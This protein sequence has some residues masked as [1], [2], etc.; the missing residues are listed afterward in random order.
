[1]RGLPRLAALA[2]AAAAL[3]VGAAAAPALTVYG[4]LTPLAGTGGCLR[5]PAAAPA[6]GPGAS[7]EGESSALVAPGAVLVSSDSQTVYVA[8]P[9]SDAVLALRRGAGGTLGLIAHPSSHSCVGAPAEG[10]AASAAG[11]QG[12]DALAESPDGRFLYA[13]SANAAAVVALARARDGLLYPLP[14]SLA[15]GKRR[16]YGCVQGVRLPSV[17]ADGCAGRSGGLDGVAS[18]AVSPDGR[19][20]YAVSYGSASGEDSLVAFARDPHTGGLEPLHGRG[21]CVESRPVVRCASSAP[22][23]EGATALTMSRDGRFLYVASEMSGAVVAFARNPHTGQ[24]APLQGVGGCVSEATGTVPAP[25]LPCLQQAPQLDGARSLALARNG[26]FLYVAG[27]DP[28]AVLALPRDPVSGRI[29]PPALDGVHCLAA[30][31]VTGCASPLPALRG[32]SAIVPSPTGRVLYVSCE[33]GD[34]LLEVLADPVTGALTPATAGGRDIGDIAG[35][36]ALAAS[37]DGRTLYVASPFDDSIAALST[38]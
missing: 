12:V 32:A 28:G 35:P 8:A 33:G 16:L 37:A 36:G 17:P 20:L 18:L 14:A 34:S 11:M 10:C 1:M 22:G 27:F 5:D 7:C 15:R 29:A 31:A 26:R 13:G 9:G 25:D 4:G 30:L 3:L 24:I 2:L 21:A 19:D 6:V 38:R 23:L